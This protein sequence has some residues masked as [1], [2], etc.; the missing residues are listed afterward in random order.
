MKRAALKTAPAARASGVVPRPTLRERHQDATREAVLDALVDLLEKDGAFEFTFFEL[1]R[2]AGV[3]VRTIYRH[4]PTRDALFD[5][6]SHRVNERVGFREYPVT[7][8]AM[9]ELPRLIFPAFD[10]ERALIKAQ[11]QAGLGRQVRA[12]AQKQR[13]HACIAAVRHEA[14]ELDEA[15]VEA[16]GG[17]ISCLLSA[18]AWMRLESTLGMDGARSGEAVSWA[19]D[20][21]FEAVRHENDAAKRARKRGKG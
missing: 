8:A 10:R 19:I 14:P 9:V 2:R 11:F 16:R 20:A 12:H 17:A 18:D 1:A 6:V 4:F 7:R 13:T 15:T 21:L 5:A 3:S